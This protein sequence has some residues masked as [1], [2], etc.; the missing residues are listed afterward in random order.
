MPQVADI[1]A[2]KGT[3]VYTVDKMATVYKAIKNMVEANIGAVIVTEDDK[4]CGIFTERD[5]LRRI[6]LEG[7]T[8][9][10]TRVEEVMTDRLI[11]V[12][13]SRD[14]EECMSI[15]TQARIRHLPVVD[16]GRLAGIVSIGDI[17]KQISKQREA[18]VRYL[19]DYIAGKYPA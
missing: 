19:T 14:L 8:S 13:N 18:E 9:R 16:N 17:I 11:V 10:T 2:N 12:D 15:M 6:V 7:K 5:Y 3:A 4:A 1:L